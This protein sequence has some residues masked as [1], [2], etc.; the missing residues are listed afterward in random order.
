MLSRYLDFDGR[1]FF[2][3]FVGFGPGTRFLGPRAEGC[4]GA[5]GAWG[6]WGLG[7]IWF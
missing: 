2:V 7:A 5:W 1:F 3:F 4:L 6:A